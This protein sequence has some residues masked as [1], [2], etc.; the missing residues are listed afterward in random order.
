[1]TRTHEVSAGFQGR[2]ACEHGQS[3]IRIKGRI[4][5]VE[6]GQLMQGEI[7]GMVAK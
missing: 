7:M 4:L 1:M 2:K 5:T 6:Q 3:A